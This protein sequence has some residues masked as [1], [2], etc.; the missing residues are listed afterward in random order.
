ML[1]P[2]VTNVSGQYP[3]S[4]VSYFA[5]Q[6]AVL[7]RLA[8]VVQRH[9]GCHMLPRHDLP[10]GSHAGAIDFQSIRDILFPAIKVILHNPDY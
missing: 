3:F 9:P 10:I 4:S 1:H 2:G 6:I 8:F 5:L 7:T